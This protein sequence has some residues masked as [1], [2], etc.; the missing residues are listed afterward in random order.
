M[1]AQA[2]AGPTSFQDGS[3]NTVTITVFQDQTKPA[4]PPGPKRI[5]IVVTKAEKDGD[6]LVSKIVQIA[7]LV[8][9][10]TVNP[11]PP[12]LLP[13]GATTMMDGFG[14]GIT[15]TREKAPKTKDKVKIKV[16]VTSSDYQG[17]IPVADAEKFENAL[18]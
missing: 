2:I 7:E 4:P 18:K 13:V 1:G 14:D 15:I 5:N 9:P 10:F 16:H 11:K 8:E 6:K 3:G 12:P 17:E